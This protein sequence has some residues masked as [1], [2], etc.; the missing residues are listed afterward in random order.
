[1]LLVLSYVHLRVEIP[2]GAN[3]I[4]Q[5]AWLNHVKSLLPVKSPLLPGEKLEGVQDALKASKQPMECCGSIKKQDPAFP[6][7]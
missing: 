4:A 2:N 3:V 6:L 7:S 5:F 1:M